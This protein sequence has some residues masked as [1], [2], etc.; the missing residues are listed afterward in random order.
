MTK[1]TTNYQYK[2]LGP[3]WHVYEQNSPDD[4]V[5]IVKTEWPAQLLADALKRGGQSPDPAPDRCVAMHLIFSEHDAAIVHRVIAIAQQV[6]PRSKGIPTSHDLTARMITGMLASYLR[7]AG[8]PLT[9]PKFDIA[10]P[11]PR[12]GMH[13]IPPGRL[14]SD[15]IDEE[16]N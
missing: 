13:F 14:P 5:G 3:S 10:Q 2:Q 9:A 8:I 12:T 1:P 4:S 15:R 6:S 11:V 7:I 16:S